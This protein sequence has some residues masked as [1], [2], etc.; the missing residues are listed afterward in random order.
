MSQGEDPRTLGHAETLLSDRPPSASEAATLPSVGQSDVIT[1]VRPE[2]A[3][4]IAEA[5]QA[6]GPT[7]HSVNAGAAPAPGEIHAGQILA[8]KYELERL[9]GQGGMGKVWKGLHLGLGV[10]V[11]VKTMHPSIAAMPDYV[12]RFRHEAHAASLLN[13]PNAV[14]VLDFGEDHGALYLVMEYLEGRSLTA[15]LRDLDAPPPLA[16]VVPILV[17]LLDAFQ[18]AHSYGIVHRDLKPDNVFLTDFSGKRTVK[19]VDFGLA[20]VDDARDKGPTLT[21]QDMVAGTPE[22]MS[23]EQC[24][25]LAVGPSADLYSIG[26][27]LTDMLQLRPPFSGGSSIEILAKQMFTQPPPLTRPEGAEPVPQL[28][29]R[30]RLDLLSKSPERRPRDADDVKVRLYEAMSAEATEA[31]LPTRK[32]DEPLGDRLARAPTWEGGDAAPQ[33]TRTRARA[34]ALL[35]LTREPGGVSDEHETGLGAHKL[36]VISVHDPGR[37]GGALPGRRHP[38]RRQPPRRGHGRAGRP[39]QGRRALPRGGVRRRPHHRAD[40]RAGRRRRRRRAALP[41]DVG[42]PRSQAGAGRS[43]GAV[44]GSPDV[45][46]GGGALR[47]RHATRAWYVTAGMA[48]GTLQAVIAGVWSRG[49]VAVAA[50]TLAGAAIGVWA[51]RDRC[52]AC[53]AVL[54][55]AVLDVACPKCS[56]PLEGIVNG[57]R[58]ADLPAPAPRSAPEPET[59]SPYRADNLAARD[60]ADAAE[61]LAT[62]TDV[63]AR[64]ARLRAEPRIARAL[65]DHDEATLHR[66]VRERRRKAQSIAEEAAFDTLLADPRRHL[67]P[68]A[69]PWLGVR[70]GTGLVLAGVR[71]EDRGDRSFIAEQLLV[72]GTYSIAP[73]GSYLARRRAEGGVEIL[74]RL[75]LPLWK[76]V[77]RA[78]VAIPVLATLALSGQLYVASRSSKVYLI[79][80]LDLR[81]T[82]TAGGEATSARLR[83]ARGARARQRQAAPRRPRRAGEHA[84]RAG[85]RRPR[86]RRARRLRRARCRADR[87]QGGLLL[88]VGQGAEGSPGTGHPRPARARERERRLSLRRVAPRHPGQRRA[89]HLGSLPAPRR[90]ARRGARAP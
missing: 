66:I 13:H 18:V 10:P 41:G 70:G 44:M 51:R 29:E 76:R 80:G 62:R 35:R 54:P 8:G 88:H 17:Q 65:R 86:R 19:V 61:R 79:N 23:P 30:L 63:E 1:N 82:V 52:S 60:A 24:R 26:C 6:A 77:W 72:L 55:L 28:L 53:G 14:R 90:L 39:A 68:G 50:G 21:S 69:R 20:H 12:R 47:V 59:T 4:Q 7:L 43:P 9:L 83:G 36:E 40:E 22:Y 81:I 33:T 45:A 3:A 16:E 87:V 32:G 73:L 15:W 78:A 27:L 84:R 5:D 49:V 85:H 89:A 67:A 56:R 48:A 37:G 46:P 34:I 64:V 38:R 74:G 31:R 57:D 25:S 2:H 42:Q 71:D 75:P 58:R 11:A